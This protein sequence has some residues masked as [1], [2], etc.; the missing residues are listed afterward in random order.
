VLKNAGA[1]VTVAENGQQAF[2]LALA[3]QESGDPFDVVL[4]DMQMPVVDGYAATKR[5]RE[6]GYDRPIIAITA[7]A[8]ESDRQ[9]CLAV[10]CDDYVAKPLDMTKLIELIRR[11][12]Q[13]SP[14]VAEAQIT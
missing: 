12:C 7:H 10:G 5:L 3:M 14:A 4:M 6:W 11:Y 2:E 13:P 8:L 1:K 9:K